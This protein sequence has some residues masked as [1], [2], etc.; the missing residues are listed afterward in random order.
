[1]TTKEGLYRLIDEL[2]DA[3]LPEAER[4]LVALRDDP[5]AL[6]LLTAP[7]DD[8]PE[9]EEERAAVEEA[10]EAAARGEV[11]TLEEVRRLGRGSGNERW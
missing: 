3:V 4:Y 5:L 10:R 8:E 9:T 1:M 2:P 7:I 11:Y 6:M